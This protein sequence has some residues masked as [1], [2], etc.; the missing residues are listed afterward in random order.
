M[1]TKCTLKSINWDGTGV[2]EK[3][4]FDWSLPINAV[5]HMREED[6]NPSR[7]LTI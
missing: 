3:N 5:L 1:F 6:T 2:Y 7:F 4:Q